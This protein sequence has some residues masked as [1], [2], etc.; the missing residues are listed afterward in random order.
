MAWD[1]TLNDIIARA[2]SINNT[3]SQGNLS[4][5]DIQKYSKEYS[6]L[7]PVVAKIKEYQSLKQ[8]ITESTELLADGDPDIAE[9]AQEE[10]DVAKS[11]IP[12]VEQD[13]K[14]MMLPKDAADSHN[15][16]MEIRA[17]A[18][19]DEAGLFAG[20]LLRMYQRFAE[21]QGWKTE[22]LEYN[23]TDLGGYNFVSMSIS[24][25]NVY[26]KLKYESGGHRVQ[27][28]P[29]TES[30]GRIHTSAATVAVLPEAEDVDIHIDP[31]DL[32]IDTYRASGAGGQHVNT[33]DSAV[34]ITHEPTGIV[35]QCQSQRSQHKNKD[36]AMKMLRA[37][38]FD[39]KRQQAEKEMSENRK[40]QVG[41]GDRSQRIKTY[42]FPERRVT[43]HR[44]SL[45]LHK[46]DKILAGELNEMLEA[47]ITAD[48]LEHLAHYEA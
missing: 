13:L 28:V 4:S 42:N 26:A 45:T 23:E 48:Q 37:L 41:S 31:S 29:E 47:M 22:V 7:E 30:G 24:G 6:T 20:D 35:A 46:L 14:I 33:T 25:D 1:D 32:R 8:S 18:G 11:Q 9:M 12:L 10:L 15:V 19:G 27:R 17:G 3:L 36:Q 38:M 39:A 44:I 5:Q 34:R 2:E 40:M 43:D 16:I 21:L